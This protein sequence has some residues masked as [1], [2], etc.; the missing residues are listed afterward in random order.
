[1]QLQLGLLG[2][3][4]F[5]ILE[6]RYIAHSNLVFLVTK[7]L[8]LVLAGLVDIFFRVFDCFQLDCGLRRRRHVVFFYAFRAAGA[9]LAG[10]S[11]LRVYIS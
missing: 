2:G 9:T 6:D 10:H 11:F 3:A 8:K 5:Q 4:P 7:F 1:M